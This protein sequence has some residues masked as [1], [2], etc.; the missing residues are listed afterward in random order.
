MRDP[1]YVNHA[2]EMAANIA[3]ATLA[4]AGPGVFASLDSNCQGEV[5]ATTRTGSQLLLKWCPTHQCIHLLERVPAPGEMIE[6]TLA[7]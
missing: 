2:A 3:L 7:A 6:V 1:F 5:I 4:D